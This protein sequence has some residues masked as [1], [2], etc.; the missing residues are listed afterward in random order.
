MYSVSLI[1]AFLLF[2][3]IRTSTKKASKDSKP[4]EKRIGAAGDS[5]V[6]S[7]ESRTENVA[8]SGIAGENHEANSIM[9]SEYAYVDHCD[10]TASVKLNSKRQTESDVYNHLN[11]VQPGPHSDNVYSTTHMNMYSSTNQESSALSKHAQMVNPS[12][13]GVYNHL[14]ECRPSPHS[15]NLYNAT[16]EGEYV[17]MSSQYDSVELVNR[18][19]HDKPDSDYNVLSFP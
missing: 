11:Q 19:H 3:F 7:A 1:I 9:T 14:N 6:P 12:E 8:A 5:T 2:Y 4:S 10:I 18:Q 16:N 13:S 17:A 15:D